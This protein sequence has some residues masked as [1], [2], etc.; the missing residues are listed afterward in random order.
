MEDQKEKVLE[1]ISDPDTICH[2]DFGEYLAIRLYPKTPLTKKHL[3]VVYKETASND[4][5]VLTAYFSTEPSKRRKTV[6]TR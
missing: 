1:T 5:F 4:G 2:G 3:V 6:W